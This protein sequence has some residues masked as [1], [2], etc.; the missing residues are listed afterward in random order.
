MAA[1]LTRG[2]RNKVLKDLRASGR[3]APKHGYCITLPEPMQ[4][5][6]KESSLCRSYFPAGRKLFPGRTTD[7][8]FVSSV[9]WR[10][11]TLT[12]ARRRRR[13]RR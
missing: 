12:G 9:G 3:K 13:R 11:P 7:Y 10:P 5:K 1:T 2:E 8:Y 6:Y 4:A